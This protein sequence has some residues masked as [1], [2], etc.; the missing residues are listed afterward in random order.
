MSILSIILQVLLALIFSMTGF[1][2]VSGNKQQIEQFEHLNLPQWFRIVTGLVQLIGA[3]GLV[4]G[5]WYPSIAA[6][7]G[8]WSAMTMLGGFATHI[9]AKDPISKALPAL[10]LAMI[11]IIITLINLS[12]LLSV[13]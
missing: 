2:S 8:L 1:M 13:F 12:E 4:I 3:V 6:L 5:I 9:K 7:A 11:A 10:I